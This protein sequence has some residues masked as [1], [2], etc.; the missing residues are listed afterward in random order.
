[1]EIYFW[2]RKS[3]KSPDVGTISCVVKIDGVES[4]PFSTKIKTEKKNWNAGEQCFEGKDSSMKELYKENIITSLRI[5]HRRLMQKRAG[6]QLHPDDVKNLFLSE[7]N[8]VRKPKVVIEFLKVAEEYIKHRTT[9]L[10]SGNI[11]ENTIKTYNVRRNNIE[12]FLIATNR[13]RLSIKDFDEQLA[14]EYVYYLLRQERQKS[15]IV[16]IIEFI[17][18]VGDYAVRKKYMKKALLE[19]FIIKLPKPKIPVV[20]EPHEVRMIENAEFEPKLQPF[21]DAWLFCQETSLAYTDYHSLKNN[22]LIE[23]DEG[24]FWID[25]ERNKTKELQQIPLSDKALRILEKYEFK[26]ENLPHFVPS[27]AN[28]YIKKIAKKLGIEKHLVFHTSR[29]TFAHHNLNYKMARE[30]TIANMM[31]WGSTAPLKI[32]ARI[33]KNAIKKEFFKE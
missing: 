1:M 31:G 14:D 10:E 2:Y 7:K 9:L 32:Y 13:R 19:K 17:R 21:V 6:E 18:A 11:A 26:L 29:K 5:I 24:K 30:I 23:D 33:N 28:R 20:L 12:R 16:G 15:Y 25:K 8:V 3:T 27:T 4:S 22:M